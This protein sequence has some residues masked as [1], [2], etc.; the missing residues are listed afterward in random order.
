[1]RIKAEKLDLGLKL[2]EAQIENFRHNV[3]FD[4][5]IRMKFLEQSAKYLGVYVENT[6]ISLLDERAI[7]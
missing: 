7:S 6:P 3:N 4:D 1:M 2:R 5:V